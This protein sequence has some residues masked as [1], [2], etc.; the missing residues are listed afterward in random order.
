[1]NFPPTLYINLNKRKDRKKEIINH[2]T[3]EGWPVP[4]ERVEAIAKKPGYIGCF[5]SHM[6]CI[7]I[8]I[9]RDYD[10]VLIL[11]DDCVL[12]PGAKENFTKVL[13]YLWKERNNDLWDIYIGGPSSISSKHLINK[14]NKIFKVAGLSTHFILIHKD[15]CW[16]ILRKLYALKQIEPIDWFY[17]NNLNILTSVPYISIQ[18]PGI[19][20][21]KNIK[22]KVDYTELFEKTEKELLNALN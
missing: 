15:A 7:E 5:L 11:E 18:R 16:N 21:V 14:K 3:A 17:K 2:F 19:S 6:K 8:A 13:P 22:D 9:Q 1:M 4:L 10:W 12:K 20:N